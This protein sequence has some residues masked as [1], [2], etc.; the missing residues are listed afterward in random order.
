M[1]TT[2]D[3]RNG[4]TIRFR[5]NLWEI[6]EFL[7]VKPGKG[8]AFVRT[9]LKN[10][11]T[12]QVVNNTFRGGEKIEE[13]RLEGR[14]MQYLYRDGDSYF[15]MDQDTYEQTPLSGKLL[16]ERWKFIKEGETLKV[17]FHGQQPVQIEL[18]LFV[19][20]KVEKTEPGLKGD[21][22]S[23]GSKPATVETGA[24]VTVPL[25]IEEGDI[26]KID[27]RSGSYIERIKK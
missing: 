22:A 26:L 17:L 13:V 16:G 6:I 1:A 3:F 18:P 20:L 27:T 8:G 12:G 11:R 21:T 2:A 25:F 10:V 24:V 23:G 19:E 15:F 7:H 5:D 9:K 14:P 4:M